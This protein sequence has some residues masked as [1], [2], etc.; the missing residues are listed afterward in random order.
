MTMTLNDSMVS[1]DSLIATI[2]VTDSET[3]EAID[4][5]GYRATYQIIPS[6]GATVVKTETGGLVLSGNTITLTLA[7]ADTAALRGLCWHELEIYRESGGVRT[8]THT[9]MRGR[10]AVTGDAIHDN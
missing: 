7:P 6:N 2:P 3:G 8:Q 4:L 1:G 10:L 5:T 9:V